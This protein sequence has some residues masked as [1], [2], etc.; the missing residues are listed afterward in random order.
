[1]S[2]GK[3]WTE[4]ERR[5]FI[6][7]KTNEVTQIKYS[8]LTEREKYMK[9]QKRKEKKEVKKAMEEGQW[10]TIQNKQQIVVQEPEPEPDPEPVIKIA[11]FDWSED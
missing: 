4:S 8:K 5:E 2:S 10:I 6:R 1:M 11:R 9:E 3:R 7:K